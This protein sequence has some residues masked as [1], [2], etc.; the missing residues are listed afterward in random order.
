MQP[1]SLGISDQN[2][3]NEET[4]RISRQVSR[5]LKTQFISDNFNSYYS[6]TILMY[7]FVGIGITLTLVPFLSLVSGQIDDVTYRNI[8]VKITRNI[9]SSFVSLVYV[10]FVR[11]KS[12]WIESGYVSW[13][14]NKQGRSR[15]SYTNNITPQ[16]RTRQSYNI[17]IGLLFSELS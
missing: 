14:S 9:F 3:G 10:W 5:N 11:R 7:F 1:V 6:A 15:V 8:A 13:P 17:P 2:N 4:E 12:K 16:G